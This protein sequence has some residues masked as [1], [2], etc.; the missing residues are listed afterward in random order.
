MRWLLFIIV[1]A[2]GCAP[3]EVSKERIAGVF[4]EA[5]TVLAEPPAVVIPAPAPAGSE[6]EMCPECQD[7]KTVLDGKRLKECPRCRK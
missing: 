2:S 3:T 7:T 5:A 4:V 1:L 6:R